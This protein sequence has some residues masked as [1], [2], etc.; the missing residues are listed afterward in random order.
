SGFSGDWRGSRPV[1]DDPMS[2]SLPV[3]RIARISVRVHLFFLVFVLVLLTHAAS[4]TS[5]GAIGVL[6]TLLG[7]VALFL[8][9]LLHEFGH[10]IA[11]RGSGGTADEILLW[12]LGG[13]ASC[14]PPD[15]P[16]AHLWTAVGGPL[17]NVA[18]I[19]ALTPALGFSSGEWWGYAIPD[20][21]NLG[22]V[23]QSADFGED[24][25]GWARMFAF[26][27]NA[28]A[29]FLLV[30]NLLPMFP[31]DGGR[32]L[33]ALLWERLGYTRSMRIAC[34]A[35]IV[36]AVVIG[37]SALIAESTMLLG[38]AIFGGFTCVMT[39]RHVEQQRDFL[40]FEPDPAELAAMEE[41]VE[42]ETAAR[43][44]SSRSER[45]RE[46]SRDDARK[47]GEAEIDRILAKIA[48]SGIESLSAAERQTL[49]RA[50][51]ERRGRD[52]RGGR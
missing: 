47:D 1:F 20:P 13:L 44:E 14:N 5:D 31:L 23:L 8:V 34:R 7:L 42:L 30:F 49:Q 10:C 51:D 32:I 37:V 35:G 19:A 38:I 50:T 6:P 2:W 18:L 3:A 12:P 36:G 41:E 46:Q 28:I 33:Q 22:G 16:R 11:C 43:R 9:V 52:G 27:T 21:R 48:R 26:F 40:G 25:A 29:W 4:V 15:R 39:A 17:V 24:L 45:T